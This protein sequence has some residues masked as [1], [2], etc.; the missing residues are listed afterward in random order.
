M[1]K[2]QTSQTALL[3][4]APKQPYQLSNDH[5][6]PEVDEESEILIRTQVIGLNPLDWKAPYV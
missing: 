2:P 5:A 6:V 4:H 3:L 1:A